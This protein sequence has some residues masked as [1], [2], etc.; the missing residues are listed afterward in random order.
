MVYLIGVFWVIFIVGFT[1]MLSIYHVT[2]S[3]YPVISTDLTASG[4]RS[5]MLEVSSRLNCLR[6]EL[7]HLVIARAL[8]LASAI[9]RVL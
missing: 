5:L 1:Q 6:D 4:L 7:S 2:N 3:L 8:V 9:R